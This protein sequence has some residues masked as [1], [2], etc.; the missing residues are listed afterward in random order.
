MATL[1]RMFILLVGFLSIFRKGK[2][3]NPALYAMHMSS[4]DVSF[5]NDKDEDEEE[6]EDEDGEKEDEDEEEEDED[7]DEDELKNSKKSVKKAKKEAEDAAEKFANSLIEKITNKAKDAK[8][9]I[10]E[11]SDG[12]T[13]KVVKNSL[14]VLTNTL[15]R[16][17]DRV[18]DERH[19]KFLNAIR[20]GDADYLKKEHKI[21]DDGSVSYR[22]AAADPANTETEAEGGF[23]TQ[24]NFSS[25]VITKIRERSFITNNV[26]T[27][28]MPA[29][30]RPTN[31]PT[32]GDVAVSWVSEGSTIPSKKPVFGRKILTMHKLGVIVPI[33]NE[34]LS[35]AYFGL[36]SYIRQIVAEVI[37][38]ELDR[39]AIVGTLA[40]SPF[41]G[42]LNNTD[43]QNVVITRAAPS[44]GNPI[45][46][47]NDNQLR[48]LANGSSNKAIREGGN[49]Y[50]GIDEYDGL[51]L[52]RQGGAGTLQH[53]TLST[54]RP[55]ILRSG[56]TVLKDAPAPTGTA[57]FSLYG[58][59]RD[60]VLAGIVDSLSVTISREAVAQNPSGSGP[61][62]NAFTDDLT[63]YRFIT[64]FGI[65]VTQ[66]DMLV[67]GTNKV[68]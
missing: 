58:R 17:E 41:L 24:D 12:V 8:K 45:E 43:I 51:Q 61:D 31:I 21:N 13:K 18:Q 49:Y 3:Q 5:S 46:A 15:N 55:R 26:R 38:D 25:D 35:G 47:L 64:E 27:V 11:T 39:A 62:L 40:N 9:S 66:D 37:S 50:I 53:P 23:A 60:A 52:L 56:V 29:Y 2:V 63:L 7:E 22:N 59:L 57:G 6:D 44:G 28:S 14:T 65:V 32:I 34:L 48:A 68:G 20:N 1:K 33:T 19:F 30:S 4:F 10:K 42:L 16:N 36:A 67:R 54:D